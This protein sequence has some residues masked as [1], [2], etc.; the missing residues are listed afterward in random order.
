[1]CGCVSVVVEEVAAVPVAC[2]PDRTLA[3]QPPPL[4]PF[5][6]V[7]TFA[8]H[9]GRLQGSFLRDEKTMMRLQK[10]LHAGEVGLEHVGLDDADLDELLEH[11]L[12][13]SLAI[14]LP[15]PRLDPSSTLSFDGDGGPHLVAT[16]DGR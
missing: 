4:L 12:D 8:V 9:S 11:G 2:R 1:M 5:S 10:S 13:P 3:M 7:R 6:R 16:G 14:L 15:H